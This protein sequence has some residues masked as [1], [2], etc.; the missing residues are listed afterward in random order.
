MSSV[1]SE[2]VLEGAW[3]AIWNSAESTQYVLCR[4]RDFLN[5]TISFFYDPVGAIHAILLLSPAKRTGFPA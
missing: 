5:D 3:L 2:N 1:E 4:T